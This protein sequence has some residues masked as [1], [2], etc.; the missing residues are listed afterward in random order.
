MIKAHSFSFYR[1]S[2]TLIGDAKKSHH[3]NYRDQ[4]VCSF[5]SQNDTSIR[6][7]TTGNGTINYSKKDEL[8][9][10]KARLVEVRIVFGLFGS[11]Q[12]AFSAILQIHI[13]SLQLP[14]C[15]MFHHWPLCIV[16]NFGLIEHYRYIIT[17]NI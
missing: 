3:K 4:P 9:L 2:S 10:E 11:H 13:F 6:T 12:S 5:V 8:F 17:K 15:L 1:T 14:Q 7:N 16:Y